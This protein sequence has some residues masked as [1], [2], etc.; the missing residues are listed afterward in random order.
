[1]RVVLS[2][3]EA[4]SQTDIGLVSL[5]PSNFHHLLNRKLSNH[6]IF[7][8]IKGILGLVYSIPMLLFLLNNEEI[9]IMLYR[10]ISYII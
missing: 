4:W 9:E 2:V 1:M 10:T 8:Q 6:V 5:L 7:F 3:I